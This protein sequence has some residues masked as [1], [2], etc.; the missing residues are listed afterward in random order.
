[1]T[2]K[3][4]LIWGVKNLNSPLEAEILLSFLLKKPKEYLYTWPEKKV[5]GKKITEYKKLIKKR[6]KGTPVPYLIKKKEFYGFNFYVDENVLIPRPESELLIDI[7][8]K[9]ILPKK[10]FI[11][12]DVGTGSGCLAITLAKLFP[13]IKIY[14]LDISEKALKIAKLNAKKHNIKNIKF[15]QSDLLKRAPE[16]ANLI[17]ANLPYVKTKKISGELKFEPEIAL[18]GGKNGLKIIREFLKQA[19]KY[20]KKNGKILIEIA[21]ELKNKILR[22][23]KKY[24]KK[25]EIKKD[26]SKKERIVILKKN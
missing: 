5:S 23:A 24:F 7:A 8:L 20:L 11:I 10:K 17:I 19:P 25:V 15:I 9:F 1:M 12:I 4:L 14:A 18:N 26:L 2:I 21:P 22:E 6:Q 13:K 16:K 3:N